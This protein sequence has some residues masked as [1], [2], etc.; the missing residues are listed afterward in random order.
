MHKYTRDYR[1]RK[2]TFSQSSIDSSIV[3]VMSEILLKKRYIISNDIAEDFRI[4]AISMLDQVIGEAQNDRQLSYL[5]G[6]L[7]NK[8]EIETIYDAHNAAKLFAFT[9]LRRIED[10]SK[11]GSVSLDEISINQK[12]GRYYVRYRLNKSF[13]RKLC[14]PPFP[15]FCYGDSSGMVDKFEQPEKSAG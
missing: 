5:Y 10:A 13:M 11:D 15:P 7:N 4:Y 6:R 8:E 12:I 14:P 3:L 1:N 9:V 2:N